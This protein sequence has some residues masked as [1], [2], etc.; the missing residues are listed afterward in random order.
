VTALRPRTV[1]RT[2]LL[3][4]GFWPSPVL[5]VRICCYET[6]A[7]VCVAPCLYPCATSCTQQKLC[8]GLKTL[9]S[10]YDLPG[11]TVLI[12]LSVPLSICYVNMVCAA[13]GRC[14][15]ATIGVVR[16]LLPLLI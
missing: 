14:Q 9:S 2:L 8:M 4:D 16:E 6:L 10:S 1:G 13:L 15:W 12:F 7:F 3:V 11:R 5:W